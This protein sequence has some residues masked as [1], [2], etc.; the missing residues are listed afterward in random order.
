MHKIK[1]LWLNES[2]THFSAGHRLNK[3]NKI[4]DLV[5]NDFL[6]LRCQWRVGTLVWMI[7]ITIISHQ[8]VNKLRCLF[9]WWFIIIIDTS[10][11]AKNTSI[12]HSNSLFHKT[13]A[14]SFLSFHWGGNIYKSIYYYTPAEPRLKSCLGKFIWGNM[15]SRHKFMNPSGDQTKSFW[16]SCCCLFNL[17]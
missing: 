9:L 2:N 4:F 5:M 6:F 16:P 17:G 12:T 10:I 15:K 3:L 13:S 1:P 11:N 14:F 7:L 8:W